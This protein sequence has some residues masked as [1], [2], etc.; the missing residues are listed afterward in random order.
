MHRFAISLAA[1]V[2]LLVG[3]AAIAQPP[4]VAQ[5][6]TPMVETEVRVPYGEADGMPLHLDIVLPSTADPPHPAVVLFP[7]WNESRYARATEAQELAKAG[8]AA[9]MVD[10]RMDWPE[11]IDDGQLAVRWVRANADRYGID[12]DRIC[13]YGH[14]SGGQLAAMLAVRDTRDTA[15]PPLAEYSSRVTCAV[16]LAG[17]ADASLPSPVSGDDAWK[18]EHLGGTPEEVPEAYQDVS[19]AALV[20][21]QSA[22]MLVIQGAADTNNPVEQS[23]RLVTALHEAGVEVVYAELVGEDHFTVADWTRTG[24]LVL[25]FL[26]RHLDPGG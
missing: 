14:S 9:V 2:I 21:E 15:D 19:P 25:A 24:P 7:G 10:Y 5:E 4:A 3:S 17:T 26:N 18:A 13:A 1:V 12:P 8:Y 16:D 22:P 20:D 6:A 23:R 11:F